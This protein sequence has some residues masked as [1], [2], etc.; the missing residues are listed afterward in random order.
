M[1][2]FLSGIGVGVDWDG[3]DDLLNPT[4]GFV[5]SGTV[6]PVGDFLGGDF[7][8]VRAV[9]EGRAYFPLI[10]RL[11]GAARLRLGAAEPTNG[12]DEVPLVERFFAGGINSVRGYERRHVG[13]LVDGDPLGGRTLIET[14][15]ELRHPITEAIG[16]ATFIDGGQVS[17]RSFTFP[18]GHLRYGTGV[19]VR[20]KSPVGPLR[21]DLGFPLQPPRG[22]RSW[23]V[24]VSLGAAF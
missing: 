15:I 23:Q 7:S 20:Y 12:S 4:R 3:T 5:L 16:V 17:P 8:F 21:L 13:P 6:E 2:G 10:R 9:W 14:S 1:D 19:G 11:L 22:D 24:H 18:F